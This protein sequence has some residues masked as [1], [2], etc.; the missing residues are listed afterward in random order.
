MGLTPQDVARLGA[1][2]RIR[3]TDAECAELAPEL[4]II[5]TS[6]QEVSSV[7]GPHVPLTTHAVPMVN[8]FRRDEVR[9]SLSASQA[10]SGAPA[11]EEDR[12]RVP[13]I[14]SEDA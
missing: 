14:L 2:A 11:A 6:V 9:S 4:D 8:V 13:Q 12:F 7:A 1:L 10:L 3:L 5:L